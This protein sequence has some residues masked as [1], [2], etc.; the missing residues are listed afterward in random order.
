MNKRLDAMV[1]ELLSLSLSAVLVHSDDKEFRN[2]KCNRPRRSKN[3]RGAEGK[4]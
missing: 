1:E 4:N 2:A 3:R